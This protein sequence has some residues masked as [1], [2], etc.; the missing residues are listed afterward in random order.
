MKA[1]R[2]KRLVV[3]GTG[4][5]GECFQKKYEMVYA[6]YFDLVG[7]LDKSEEKQGKLFYGKPVYSPSQICS[8]DWDMILICTAKTSYQDEMLL[9]LREKG[10]ERHKIACY[11]NCDGIGLLRDVFIEKYKASKDPE[12]REVLQYI[13]DHELTVFNMEL[14][15][16]NEVYKLYR[17]AEDEDPYVQ[18]GNKRLYFPKELYDIST[19]P[20]IYDLYTEQSENSPHLYI[21]PELHMEKNAVIVDAGAREG[22]FSLGYVEGCRKL[23]VI[24]CE[25]IWCRAL[26]RT[27]S[28]YRGKVEIC[29]A[30]LGKESNEE[31]KTIDFLIHEPVDFLKM[32]IEGAETDALAGAKRVLCESSAVCAICAYHKKND[33]DDIKKILHGY[34]YQTGVSRGYMLYGWDETVFNTM[35][36]RRGLVFGKKSGFIGDMN[37]AANGECPDARI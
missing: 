10:I 16:K 23:Y 31:S 35:D 20:Y 33:E 7:Y 28:P 19:T 36:V 17:D 1:G 12:I 8:M 15:R 29:R 24:E 13:E 3:W 9:Y 11:L 14:N 6:P 22:N 5:I 21:P 37:Y 30:F 32:D 25:K 4:K 27:F 18:V 2:K 26:E 34:G